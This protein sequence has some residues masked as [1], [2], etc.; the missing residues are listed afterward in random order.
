MNDELMV[1]VEYRD[2]DDAT[3]GWDLWQY[4]RLIADFH[5]HNGDTYKDAFHH[6]VDMGFERLAEPAV[7][8][9]NDPIWQAYAA[10]FD[11]DAGYAFVL[12]VFEE[13]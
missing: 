12:D 2:D 9:W 1:L 7:E 13:D 6:A 4:G 5:V 8:D 3:T 11:T 10:P